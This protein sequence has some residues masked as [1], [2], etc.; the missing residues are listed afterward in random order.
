MQF[1]EE[2]LKTLHGCWEAYA[3][4]WL[5]EQ[6][7][8]LSVMKGAGLPVDEFIKSSLSDRRHVFYAGV[9]SVLTI[10]SESFRNYGSEEAADKLFDLFK[11]AHETIE[12]IKNASEERRAD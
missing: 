3:V 5:E 7:G 12:E 2:R 1:D 6:A 4:T 10:I 8:V 9:M 11:E